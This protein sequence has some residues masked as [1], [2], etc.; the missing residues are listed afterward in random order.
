MEETDLPIADACAAPDA[1]AA[2]AAVLELGKKMP[3]LPARKMA[4]I[5]VDEASVRLRM[6]L[7]LFH[8]SRGD[9]PG[10][11]NATPRLQPLPQLM[12][13]SRNGGKRHM[14]TPRP[15]GALGLPA[16]PAAPAADGGPKKAVPAMPQFSSLKGG[17]TPKDMEGMRW[18][19]SARESAVG[20][21]T[22]MDSSEVSQK[23]K[24]MLYYLQSFDRAPLQR[25]L[26]SRDGPR[27]K[28]EPRS[29]RKTRASGEATEAKPA[30][31]LPP[32]KKE[33][34]RVSSQAAAWAQFLEERLGRHLRTLSKS[35]PPPR[36]VKGRDIRSLLSHGFRPVFLAK[37]DSLG[38][39]LTVRRRCTW[40]PMFS[41]QWKSYRMQTTQSYLADCTMFTRW[42]PIVIK[43]GSELA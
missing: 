20:S 24:E 8:R 34:G 22:A 21:R 5:P 14:T 43:V 11:P 10:P 35:T 39:V 29:S 30:E 17:F 6:N 16:A 42:C 3:L 27:A 15:P 26:S 2:Q 41:S 23:A 32:I 40:R 7:M 31:H 1:A 4:E 36:E 12:L 28:T 19:Q 25:L 18:P 33:G 13:G 37:N 38:Q 9:S